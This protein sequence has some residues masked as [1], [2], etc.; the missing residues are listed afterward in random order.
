MKFHKNGSSPSP[1]EI[2]VF[3]S[4]EAGRHGLGAALAARKYYGAEYG[5]PEGRQGNSYA[6]PTKDKELV[7]LPIYKISQYVDTFVSYILAHP[8]TPFFIT[9]IGTQLA[10]YSHEDIAPLFKELSGVKNVNF[11]M[12]WEKYL[13]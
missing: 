10:G 8:N 5:N 3:G 6:I 13:V 9:A 1:L 12:E 4:N 11:P 7:S 2:F